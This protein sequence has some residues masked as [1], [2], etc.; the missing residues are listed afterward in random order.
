MITDWSRQGWSALS[1]LGPAGRRTIWLACRLALLPLLSGCLLSAEKADPAL[2]IPSS[3]REPHGA[4]NSHLPVAEW[5]RGFQ[6]AELDGLM[7]QAQIGNLDIAVAIAQI[8]QADALA[9]QAGAALL[10]TLTASPSDTRSRSS[11]R[12][13]TNVIS[14]TDRTLYATPL[15]ASYVIDF[16]GKNRATLRAAEET[17]VASRYNREVV[18]LTTE[19]T[20]ADDYFTILASQ[21]RLRIAREN[22]IAANRILKLIRDRF[23][24]GTAAD[25]DV[26]QQEALTETVQASIPPL[27]ETVHQNID[28]LAVLVGKAPEQVTIHG[29]SLTRLKPPQVS[30]GLP[31]A[32]LYQRPDIRDAE[33]TLASSDASVEAA[34]AAFFP[35]IT[36]TA[37]GGFESAMLRTLFA[38]GAGFYTAAV[39]LTQPIFDGGLLMG[40]FDQ[41]KGLQEQNLQAYRKA[42]ISAFSNVDQALIAI[43]ET[44]D[45]E[46][47]QTEVVSSS[48]RAFDLTEERLRAGTVDM[49]TVLQTEQTLFTAEDTLAQVRLARFEAYVSLF[50]ALGGGWQV[51]PATELASTTGDRAS[52]SDHHG[53]SDSSR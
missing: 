18:A 38:P 19:M 41:Q 20:V 46:R 53:S 37:T 22:Y 4:A 48:R 15:S 35:N 45:Q 28:A 30:P 13:G 10:P 11:S 42:V 36:L 34:R 8:V 29:G 9:R 21:D 39:G 32:L 24:S 52:H 26:A 40:Q 51:N 44:T 2:D 50:Q 25:L 12:T 27:I 49:T 23:H 43:R 14:V 5:W 1:A 16:W 17:A 31:S 3:Y 47:Y 7:D 6:S 33:A